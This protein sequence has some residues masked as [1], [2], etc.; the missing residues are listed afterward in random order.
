MVRWWVVVGCAAVAVVACTPAGSPVTSPTTTG[1]T[2]SATAATG[3]TDVT[4]ASPTT[5]APYPTDVPAAARAHDVAGAEAFVSYWL[6][7]LSYSWTT[8]ASPVVSRLCLPTSKSCAA[9][10][11]TAAELVR[12]GQHYSGPPATALSVVA[13]TTEGVMRVLVRYRQEPRSVL[14]RE[15]KVVEKVGQADGRLEFALE[16]GADG[17]LVGLIR[18]V[19]DST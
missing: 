14:D 6:Q 16:R 17:W 7:Q 12:D 3:S 13:L 19:K 5:M 2:T 10:E 11:Q 9:Y 8:P 15:G 18:E 4:S 1:A